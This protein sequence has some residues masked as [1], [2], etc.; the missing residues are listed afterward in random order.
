MS[1]RTS[2][3]WSIVLLA[4]ALATVAAGARAASS[5]DTGKVITITCS[6]CQ[7]SPTDPFLQFNYAAVQRFNAA[8]RGRYE[9]KVVQNP[10]AGSG[11]QRLQYYQRLALARSLPDVFLLQRSELQT[12]E[13]SRQLLDFAPTLAAN[14]AW[15]RSFYP[16]SFAALTDKRGRIFAIP[17]ERDSIGIY[18]NK[19]LFAKVGISRFPSTWSELR[20]DCARFKAAGI[21]CFAMDGNWVTL[22]MWANLI[23]TQK[24]GADFL[25][26][27][28]TRGGYA[29]NRAVVRATEFLRALHTDG[30]VNADAFTGDYNNAATP[31]VQGQ[32]AMIANGPW[33]VQSDIKGKNAAADLYTHV[34][35]APSP[36]WSAAGRGLIVVA[37]NGGWVSGTRDPAK[38]AAV[39]AFMKFLSSPQMA[40]RQTLA[41]GAYPSVKLALGRSQLA[42][43]EPLAYRLVQQ[44]GSVAYRYT[45]AYFA[46]PAAFFQEWTNDW[47][48]YVQ[49]GMDTSDFLA[50]L[51]AAATKTGP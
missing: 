23:G 27:G 14:P 11:P 24:G 26:S 45:D 32:A 50:K 28:T 34:G 4:A 22:L 44:S 30:Y 20:A 38:R 15:K 5:G 25:L 13:S 41:T 8:Y 19:A 36:G 31:F 7:N 9:V 37:G 12:L 47:P 43:L 1:Q 29:G 40:Y 21:T 39:V 17:Q 46:T 10:Y 16:G 42:K 33:M 2:V 51:A 49:G 35:Y 6:A 18:Y 3:R 48:A